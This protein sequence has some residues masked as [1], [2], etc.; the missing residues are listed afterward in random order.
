MRGQIIDIN[1][2]EAFIKLEDGRLISIPSYKTNGSSIGK[3]IY[4]TDTLS[5]SPSNHYFCKYTNNIF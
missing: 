3:Y 5:N 1:D 2:I 4:L